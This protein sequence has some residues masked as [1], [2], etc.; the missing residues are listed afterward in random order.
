MYHWL[1]FSESTKRDLLSVIDDAVTHGADDWFNHIIE[2]NIQNNSQDDDIARLRYL[3]QAIQLIR[4]DLQKAL[5]FYDK[6]FQKTVN[7]QY[8]K[9]LYIFYQAKIS[10]LAE[11]EVRTICKNLKK[12]SFT[13]MNLNENESEEALAGGTTLFEL[14][15]ALHRFST[16]GK[17]LC[18]V[19]FDTFHVRNFHQ[20]FHG[21]VAQWLDI[22]V[23]KA[24]QRIEKAVE[25]DAFV[26]VSSTLKYSSS[27]VDTITIFYQVKYLSVLVHIPFS[28]HLQFMMV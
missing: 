15:L 10:A 23:Y 25:L 6:L 16:L 20:W 17:G 24:L 28:F 2:N 13:G 11:P 7:F 5:E 3:I 19:D 9:A 26:P 27:A 12:L 1:T 8:A 21:G 4:S 22:A 14:Y 18:P